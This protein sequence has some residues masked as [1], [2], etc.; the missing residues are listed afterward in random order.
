[1]IVD[2]YIVT[3]EYKKQLVDYCNLLAPFSL[4]HFPFITASPLPVFSHR[5]HIYY[6][7]PIPPLFFPL[8]SYKSKLEL[9][10]IQFNPS[11]LIL[12]LFFSFLPPFFFYSCPQEVLP[13]FFFPSPIALF[14]LS[15]LER[16]RDFGD[17]SITSKDDPK[18]IHSQT[19]DLQHLF[20]TV[21]NHQEKALHEIL[22]AV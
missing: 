22:L 15:S 19:H 8:F 7:F 20:S 5:I 17:E 13:F 4:F 10:Q 3:K 18:Y 6:H 11:L 12:S 9:F 14:I 2:L 21:K 1:M 16:V